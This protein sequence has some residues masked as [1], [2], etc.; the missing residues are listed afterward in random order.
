MSPPPTLIAVWVN[1]CIGHRNYRAFLLMLVHLTA[2]ALHALCLLLTL[3]TALVQL[4][5]GV[6]ENT[7]A[8][9]AAGH[10]SPDDPDDVI[11]SSAL[12]QAKLPAGWRVGWTGPFWAHAWLQAVATALALPV[13]LGLMILLVWNASL[14]VQNRTTI[15][16]HEGVNAALPDGRG[17]LIFSSTG[18]PFDLGG[19]F[20]NLAGVCGEEVGLWGLPVKAA[21]VGDGLTFP[22][23]WSRGAGEDSKG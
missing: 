21:A 13:A 23:A 1:G 5:L 15:E 20:S 4:A 12:D 2:A 10:T 9:A 18:H 22:T 8:A 17:G 11:A 6:D 7:K 3:D 16:Y 19:W 14:A